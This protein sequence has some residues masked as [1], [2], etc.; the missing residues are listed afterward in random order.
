MERNFKEALKH[1]RSYYGIKNES[2][3]SDEQIQ[4]IMNFAVLHTPSAFNTQTSRIVLLLGK[5][6]LKMWEIVRETLRK[7]VPAEKFDP[8]DQKMD[9]FANGYGT[10]LFFE[11]FA[12]LEAAKDG[13][14]SYAD[15]FDDWSNHTAGMHQLAVWTM[16]EDAGFGASLQH[17]N[18]IIDDEVKETWGINKDWKLV[19]QMPFGMPTAE[20][21]EK[22]FGP[23]TERVQVFK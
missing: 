11:D 8:T 5:E 19:A 23:L 7:I 4:E 3:I 12:P 1:R 16:L 20:P 17:Y 13:A 14:G 22:E 9:Y 15:K 18:T 10:V 2:P 6:H 21:G